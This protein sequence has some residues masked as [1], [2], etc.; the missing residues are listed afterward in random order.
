[1]KLTPLSESLDTLCHW[2]FH[3]TVHSRNHSTEF[4]RAVQFLEQYHRGILRLFINFAHDF[5]IK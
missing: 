4:Y 1:M 2:I 5:R 3:E